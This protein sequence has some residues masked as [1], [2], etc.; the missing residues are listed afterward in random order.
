[1]GGR[2]RDDAGRPRSTRPRDALGRPLPYGSRGVTRIPDEIGLSPIESLAYAQRL[3][4]QGLAFNAHEVLEAAWKSSP[5]DQKPLW[6]GLA[7]LAVGLTHVQRS[8]VDGA[9]TVLRRASA[10]LAAVDRPAPH[11]VDVA[12][13][14]DHAGTLVRGLLAGVE[15]GADCLRPALTMRTEGN[16]APPA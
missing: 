8:N 1:M 13:V 9:I 16:S 12:G 5:V 2:D 14:I 15:I 3:L 6:Q 11:S 10:R 4:D 7:Q